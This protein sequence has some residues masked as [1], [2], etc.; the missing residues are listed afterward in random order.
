MKGFKPILISFD[1]ELYE[2]ELKKAE[3]KLKLLDSASV[4]ICNVLDIDKLNLRKL[5]NNLVGYFKDLLLEKFSKQNTFGLSADKLIEMKEIK[6][7]ELLELQQKYLSNNAKLKVDNNTANI[8]VVRKDYE[9]YTKSD[10]QNTIL[11]SYRE[12]LL[13]LDKLQSN[14]VKVYKNYVCM[15]TG[16]FVQIDYRGRY[17]I[18][19]D[20]LN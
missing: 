5:H 2:L 17:K 12:F 19:K 8:L 6:I 20:Y 4:W 14:G 1:K 15:A 10:R 13:V 7:N 3:E 16:N 9:L 11:M 18:N